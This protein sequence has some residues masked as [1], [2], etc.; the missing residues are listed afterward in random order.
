MPGITIRKYFNLLLAALFILCSAATICYAN[1]SIINLQVK[2]GDTI[3]SILT[4]AGIDHNIKA[5]ALAELSHVYDIQNPKVGQKIRIKYE[6]ANKVGAGLVLNSLQISLSSQKRMEVLRLSGDNFVAQEIVP[7]TM[8][9]IAKAKGTVNSTL[10]SAISETA[11]PDEI[12]Q[13]FIKNYTYDIDLQRDIQKGDS[14]EIIYENLYNQDGEYVGTGDLLYSSLNVGGKA[15]N[16]Y[17]YIMADGHGD[18]YDDK[19]STVQKSM[20]KTPIDGARISS[21]FGEKRG[22]FKAFGYSKSHQGLDFAAP[23]GTPIYAAGAG[24]IAEIGTKGSYGKYIRIT[25]NEKYSTAYAHMSKYADGLKAGNKVE[26]GQVI[27]YVGTTGHSTGP[28]LHYEVVTNGQQ[29]NPLSIKAL[30]RRRLSDRQLALF[31]DRKQEIYEL[32]N[33]IDAQDKMANK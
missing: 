16:I 27:G 30:S 10:F 29:V 3:G 23:K 12:R 9:K 15:Y 20:L 2:P 5:K 1:D 17:Y 8:T 7:P 13:T 33:R 19:G 32:S 31:N 14:F 26:Q 11:A 21:P 25:H 6:P 24:I 4:T 28:H 22:N 18:F